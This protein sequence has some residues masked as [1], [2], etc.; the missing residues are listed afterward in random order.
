MIVFLC[1]LTPFLFSQGK[2]EIYTEVGIALTT[3]N[4]SINYERVIYHKNWFRING[5]ISLGM[6]RET[7]YD[8]DGGYWTLGS[9]FS[10]NHG[11]HNYDLNLGGGYFNSW[12]SSGYGSGYRTF[13]KGIIPSI[14]IAYEL[15]AKWLMF[16]TGIGFPNF[17]F[18]G[19]G[20]RF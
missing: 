5:R 9:V 8:Y 3:V 19:L 7:N 1:A 2:N 13:G 12:G 20:F 10:F 18:A 11:R 4:N 6:I 15:K 17:L 14:S 16:K